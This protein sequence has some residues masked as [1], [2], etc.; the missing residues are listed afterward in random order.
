MTEAK[1]FACINPAQMLGYLRGEGSDRKFRLFGH[2]CCQDI[3]R[4]LDPRDLPVLDTVERYADGLR[5]RSTLTR[6]RSAATLVLEQANETDRRG[7]LV[8]KWL[9]H[10][11]VRWQCSSIAAESAGL[12]AS[13][14]PR[15]LVRATRRLAL[16]HRAEIL[17]DIF[18]NPFRRVTIKPEWLSP[19]VVALARGIYEDGSFDC[20]PILADA[21]QEAGCEEEPMLSHCRGP[22]LHVRGCWVVD[23]VLAK[24]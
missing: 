2:Y 14:Q 3:R 1:W 16:Q 23:A 15:H 24:E 6:A 11:D 9:C 20:L 5:S 4:L 7:A 17:R 19:A 21:L 22:G 10:E 13:L 8:V 18:G 12:V